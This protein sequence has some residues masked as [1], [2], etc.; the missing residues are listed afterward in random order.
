MM[1][2]DGIGLF[3]EHQCDVLSGYSVFMDL[4]NRFSLINISE[5]S[6]TIINYFFKNYR[7]KLNEIWTCLNLYH[8]FI[9]NNSGGRKH[10]AHKAW[11]QKEMAGKKLITVHWSKQK[12]HL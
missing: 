9:L 3:L 8:V 11:R 7:M 1:S 2:G 6:T 10:Q 5:N 12:N 4:N